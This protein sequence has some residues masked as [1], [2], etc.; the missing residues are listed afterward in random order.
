[1][2]LLIV[3][4]VFFVASP[5]FSSRTMGFIRRIVHRPVRHAPEIAV[6]VL[7]SFVASPL[8]CARESGFA[9]SDTVVEAPFERAGW[10]A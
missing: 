5:G 8:W 3:K 6:D 2:R 9:Q 4:I 1:L 10:P 7:T